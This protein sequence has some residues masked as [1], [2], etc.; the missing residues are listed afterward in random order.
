MR[1]QL[2]VAISNYWHPGTGRNQSN[3]I[4]IITHRNAQHLPSLPGRTLKGLVRD[5]V[6]RWEQYGGYEKKLVP[7]IT[8]Q[9]FGTYNHS[10]QS[11]NQIWP[12]LLR[13]SDAQLPE[14][15]ALYLAAHPNLI[16]GLYQEYFATAIDHESGTAQNDSFRSI[17]LVI[18]L[19]L[20][21]KID[22][23]PNAKYR[24]LQQQWLRLVQ[25]AL[26]LVQ[27]VGAQRSRGLGRAVLTLK[28]LE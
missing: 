25:Q 7:S 15:E 28:Q 9:L 17:E 8:E 11:N 26:P 4:E 10:S 5:A 22:L 6:Y 21:A 14:T 24:D 12:G 23:I 1:G 2:K 27:A 18:P 20:Y 19:T 3:Y 16:S 13:F